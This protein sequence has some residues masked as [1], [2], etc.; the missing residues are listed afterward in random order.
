MPGLA[1]AGIMMWLAH[2]EQGWRQA[3]NDAAGPD[4]QTDFNPGVEPEMP[5][6]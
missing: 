3:Q 6:Y 4:I 1:V 2:A 5:L